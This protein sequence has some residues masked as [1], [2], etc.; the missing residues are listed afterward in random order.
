MIMPIEL[1]NKEETQLSQGG[2]QYNA[3]KQI[4]RE[5]T[6]TEQFCWFEEIEQIDK[7]YKP[8]NQ[9]VQKTKLSPTQIQKK[10]MDIFF[11]NHW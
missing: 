10:E 11:Q 7:E 9:I 3:V 5:S 8:F 6:F 2:V 4:I 1:L